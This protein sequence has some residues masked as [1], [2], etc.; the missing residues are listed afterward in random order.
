MLTHGKKRGGGILNK[1]IDNLPF[2]L[3]IPSYKYCGPGT[4]LQ[5]RLQRGDQPINKLDAACKEHDIQYMQNHN[6]T[7]RHKADE[8]L[9][10]KAGERVSAKDSSFGEK[11][12]AWTVSKIMKLKRKVGASLE[13][14]K[15]K[16]VMRDYGK[17][18]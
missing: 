16:I 3:H 14:K 4:K 18:L 11:A 2:E 10:K 15:K 1:I 6:L 8:I 5:E 13:K 9:M 17:L 7:D 12:S